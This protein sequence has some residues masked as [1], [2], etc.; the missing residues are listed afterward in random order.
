MFG[1]V[2][3][4]AYYHCTQNIHRDLIQSIPS[5]E[6]LVGSGYD[7]ISNISSQEMRLR[8]MS[9]LLCKLFGAISD[10]CLIVLF[11]DDLHWCDETTLS[12]IQAIVTDPSD[13][14]KCLFVGCYRD[15]NQLS[16]Q[17]VTKMLDT[18]KMSVPL[19]TITLGKCF[20]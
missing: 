15:E 19:F 17:K 1:Y 14:T 6:K 12:V 7:S 10:V 5:L 3:P 11:L 9:F 13:I 2:L 4:H 8:R 20:S 18:V 16:T